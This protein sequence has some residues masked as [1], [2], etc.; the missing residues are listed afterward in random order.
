MAADGLNLKQEKIPE[1]PGA[2]QVNPTASVARRHHSDRD[3]GAG[4]APSIAITQA[5]AAST[6]KDGSVKEEWHDQE[7]EKEAPN[8]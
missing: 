4:S 6:E 8:G 3:S 2:I 1:S 5:V 7:Q